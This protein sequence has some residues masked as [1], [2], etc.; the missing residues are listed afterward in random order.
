MNEED[1]KRTIEKVIVTPDTG[2]ISF[3]MFF[4]DY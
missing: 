2:T 4:N 1:D 3:K